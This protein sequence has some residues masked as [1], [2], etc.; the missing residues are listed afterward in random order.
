MDKSIQK[1]AKYY[2][3]IL[4]LRNPK[5]R[6]IRRIRELTEGK[7]G[8]WISEEKK[9]RGGIDFYLSDQ[10]FL[11]NLGRVLQ[12]EF[13]GELKKSNRLYGTSRETSKL[14]Y[15]VFILLRMPEFEKG[16]IIEYRGNKIRIVGF[17][18]KIFARDIKTGKKMI[19]NYRDLSS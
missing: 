17:G 19:L 15:R 9:V 8:V 6:V 10:R 16:Q 12:K 4:Q 18:K 3:G 7:G 1:H 13:G 14:V 2:E 11:Q 5:E